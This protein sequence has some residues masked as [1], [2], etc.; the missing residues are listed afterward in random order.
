MKKICIK[1]TIF[2]LL[3][4]LIL[5]SVSFVLRDKTNSEF[6]LGFEDEQKNS[7][8]V[9]FLGSSMS[10]RH[11]YPLELWNNFGI[12]SYNLGTSEQTIPMSYYLLQYALEQQTPQVIVL[13]VGMCTIKEKS[14]QIFGYIKYG[15]I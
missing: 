3:F 13:D 7:L 12:V 6:I 4:C 10:Y 14:F 9:L 8:D 15:I 2:I 11:I 5:Q 1:G